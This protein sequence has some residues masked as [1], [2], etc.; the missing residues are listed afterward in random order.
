MTRKLYDCLGCDDSSPTTINLFF[1]FLVDGLEQYDPTKTYVRM[2]R[3][4][5]KVVNSVFNENA[6]Q[7][8]TVMEFIGNPIMLKYST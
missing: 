4:A 2:Q 3:I 8:N 7:G 1:E 6:I 5:Y